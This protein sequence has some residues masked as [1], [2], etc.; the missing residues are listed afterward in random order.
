VFTCGF[1]LADGKTNK[2]RT[3]ALVAKEREATA[4]REAQKQRFVQDQIETKDQA[5]R[6]TEEKKKR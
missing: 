5:K 4:V 1:Q 2:T 3:E 6:A